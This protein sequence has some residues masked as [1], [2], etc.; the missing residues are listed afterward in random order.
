MLLKREC[1]GVICFLAHPDNRQVSFCVDDASIYQFIHLSMPL[2]FTGIA[3]PPR[4]EVSNH[5]RLFSG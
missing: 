3:T 1:L 2:Q 5:I 4:A